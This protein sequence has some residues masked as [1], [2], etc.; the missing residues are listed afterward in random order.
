MGYPRYAAILLSLPSLLM[1]DSLCNAMST[2]NSRS[3]IVR[4]LRCWSAPAS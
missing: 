2:N 4:K 1:P 3:E